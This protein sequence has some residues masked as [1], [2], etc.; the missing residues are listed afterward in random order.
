MKSAERR[1]LEA[2]RDHFARRRSAI[3]LAWRKASEADPD[4]RTARALTRTQFNDHIGGV[5]DAFE[6]KL[7]AGPGGRRGAA[8][9]GMQH[10]EQVKHDLHRWQQGYR[11]QELMTEWGHLQLC[12]FEELDAFAAAQRNFPPEVLAEVNRRMI[13]LVNVAIGESAAQFERLQQAEAASHVGGLQVALER[14]KTIE[15]GRSMLIHQAVHDINSNVFGVRMAAKMLGGAADE[16]VKRAEFAALLKDGVQGVTSM[17]GELLE[18][19]RLEAGEESRELARFDASELVRAVV[20]LN[21]PVARERGLRLSGR[22]PRLLQ[23]EGD[24]GK[25]RR[26]LQNLVGN[27]LKYTD[28]GGVTLSWGATRDIWWLKVSDT[29][30]GLPG[31]GGAPLAAELIK[32]TASARESEVEGATTGGKPS[33][34]LKR[35]AGSAVEKAAGRKAAGG[36]QA[37]ANSAAGKQSAKAQPGEGIGLSIVMR[38]CELLDASLE[39]ASSAKSGTTFRIVLP[40]HYTAG[41][42]GK[43]D[44]AKGRGR[45]SVR[46]PPR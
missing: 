42:A 3:L 17:L 36:K 4:Q 20:L 24:A 1:S 35:A 13:S 10:D 5:L 26:V 22:G 38:L 32:A 14:V 18:L 8:T 33:P 9:G 23:V 11:L 30:P 6:L 37:A 2:V 44:G 28:E 15:R 12:L 25:V 39:T 27:A 34:V 43:G 41:A 46:N 45:R 19:A 16:P 29:G 7:L 31:G 40:R 21:Q